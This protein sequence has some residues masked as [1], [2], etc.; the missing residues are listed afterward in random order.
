MLEIEENHSCEC[1]KCNELER[2]VIELENIIVSFNT[3]ID[4]KIDREIIK[5]NELL[6]RTINMLERKIMDLEKKHR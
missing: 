3:G 1:C 2:K 5:N 6:L 4:N